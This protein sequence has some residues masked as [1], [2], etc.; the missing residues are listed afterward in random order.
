L[1]VG[2]VVL[3]MQKIAH[4][5]HRKNLRETPLEPSAPK[6]LKEAEELYNDIISNKDIVSLVRRRSGAADIDCEFHTMLSDSLKTL[7]DPDDPRNNAFI[8]QS[9]ANKVAAAMNMIDIVAAELKGLAKKLP[10][11]R[12]ESV[13]EHLEKYHSYA[14]RAAGIPS[15]YADAYDAC[16]IEYMVARRALREDYKI[17]RKTGSDMTI[18]DA[19][20][21]GVKLISDMVRVRL[22]RPVSVERFL[23][24]VT[25]LNGPEPDT[26]VTPDALGIASK[27]AQ[28]DTTR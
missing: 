17:S 22:A 6:P 28:P 19:M 14:L 16:R 9:R 7:S 5:V 11:D 25:K 26:E 3:R 27:S 8:Y 18:P 12:Q 13:E 1:L 20:T 4:Q 21:H 24:L 2:A 10:E 23:N 15:S